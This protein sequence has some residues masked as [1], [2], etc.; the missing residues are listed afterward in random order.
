M[1]T[2]ISKNIIVPTSIYQ[3]GIYSAVRSILGNDIEII[4]VKESDLILPNNNVLICVEYN[5]FDFDNFRL[6]KIIKTRRLSQLSDKYV[7]DE[8]I[9]TIT[10]EVIKIK[11]M[12]NFN[13]TEEKYILL[14]SYISP[15]PDILL[16]GKEINTTNVF[17]S[18]CSIFDTQYF[19]Y[20]GTNV[21]LLLEPTDSKTKF[22]SLI[23]KS[24]NPPNVGIE[25]ECLRNFIKFN[26][27]NFN[28]IVYDI[29]YLNL[30]SLNESNLVDISELT[31]NDLYAL[32]GTTGI[33]LISENRHYPFVVCKIDNDDAVLT[34]S[35]IINLLAVIEYDCYNYN[36][37]L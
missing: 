27:N 14:K 32:I 18:Y 13:T 36:L 29:S 9:D 23:K 5:T 15:M 24:V 10:N 25:L 21:Q 11:V 3:S 2:K 6:Y 30:K 12:V 20:H 37:L 33:L 17:H 4:D 35:T 22:K 19:T 8:I 16:Y 31:P 7:A 28:N 34:E 26:G 1:K